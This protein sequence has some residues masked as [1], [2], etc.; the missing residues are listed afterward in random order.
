MST[1]PVLEQK[2]MLTLPSDAVRQVQ[3]RFADR[4]DLQML[5]Q[6]ARGVA[7][8][9][10]AR[11]VSAG[12]RNT[13]EWTPEKAAMLDD[14]D[15]AGLTAVFMEPEE[16]G[17]I[18]GPKNLALSLMAFELAWVDSGAATASV[19]GFLSLA[20]IHERGTTGA[21]IHGLVRAAATR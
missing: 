1:V 7:R 12:Q 17:F 6:T 20:P 14:F 9:T 19:A 5:V 21:P 11:L 3:W 4:F 8:G 15:R 18:A 10:V 13:H 16:G 2:V